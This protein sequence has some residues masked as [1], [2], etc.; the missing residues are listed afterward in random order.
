MVKKV[1]ECSPQLSE[2]IK[3]VKFG[4]GEGFGI[5]ILRA[6]KLHRND[7]S[8]IVDLWNMK[9]YGFKSWEDAR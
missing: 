4:G 3:H 9:D 7:F 5:S 6:A 8:K 1:S 2:K